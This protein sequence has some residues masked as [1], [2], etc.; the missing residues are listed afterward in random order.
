MNIEKI[1]HLFSLKQEKDELQKQA[2]DLDNKIK[3]IDALIDD[4]SDFVLQDMKAEQ[5]KEFMADDLVVT[6]LSKHSYNMSDTSI[7]DYLE[8]NNLSQFI[9]TKKSIKKNPLN[10]ELKTN[11]E[12][13]EALSPFMTETTT[14]YVVVTT[15]E[16]A[17]KM[18][19]HINESKKTA[20]SID[21][22]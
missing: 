22:K 14:D 11:T 8:K 13:K 19:E 5:Q 7:L 2:D 6:L 17:D 10:K 20:A 21:V 18:K 4:D 15:K 16:N 3:A 1:K 9:D 12:L